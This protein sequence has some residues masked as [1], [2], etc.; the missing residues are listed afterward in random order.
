MTRPPEVSVV[1]P[2]FRDA[3]RALEAMRQI[4]AQ[5]LDGR[6]VE[7]VVVD[8]GSGDG[9]ADILAAAAPGNARLIGLPRNQGRSIARNV[10][11][12]AASASVIVFMDCDCVPAD[13]GFLDAH[14]RA[15]GDDG[16]A[17]TGAVRGTGQGFWDRYQADASARRR[18]QHAAG[19]VSAGSSQ[20]LA[21]RKRAFD[22]IGGFD[23]GYRE[24][25]FE[26]RDLL[27]RMARQGPVRWAD[28]AAVCHMDAL[29]LPAVAAKMKLAGNASAGR[30]RDA[31]PDLYA[32]L[33]YARLDVSNRPHMAR[34]LRACTPAVSWI[35]RWANPLLAHAGLPYPVRR[36]IVRAISAASFAAGTATRRT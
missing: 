32:A 16:V 20:N 28:E 27:A 36:G 13:E 19:M 18:R 11:A 15:L 9:T 29:D 1:I 24:Y 21:V 3:A 26:D 14:L 7:I 34:I 31:H 25:G 10:G 33:G 22:A 23:A 12:A 8:D 4:A 17:S 5:R 35:A 2:V 30:F 6:K